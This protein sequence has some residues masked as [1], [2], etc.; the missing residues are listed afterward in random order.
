MAATQ[1]I[2]RQ[3]GRP[4]SI[5]LEQV[6]NAACEIGLDRVE[7]VAVAHKLGVG[8]GTLYGYVRDREHL[9]QLVASRLAMRR[10]IADRGQSWEEAL[11]E[12]AASSYDLF[13]TWPELI[14]LLTNGMLGDVTDS[15]HSDRIL[16]LLIARGI[17]PV[18][19]AML[20]FRTSQAV[21]GAAVAQ[22]YYRN[23]LGRAGSSVALVEN[24]KSACVKS[25]YQA[26]LLVV[27][28]TGTAGLTLDY[29]PA[30]DALIAAQKAKTAG[31]D[32][33]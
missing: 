14:A 2:K 23:I 15:E 10:V 18:D 8:V 6:I 22:A 33:A 20:F 30:L 3:A 1:I 7:M 29:E 31:I 11:R 17:P 24:I 12:F 13:C 16:G 25:G 19:A 27:E 32:T 26:L 9:V 4:R 28:A 5:T 21:A